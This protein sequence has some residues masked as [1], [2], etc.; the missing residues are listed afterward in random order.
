MRIQ[1]EQLTL[2]Q[3]PCGFERG[4]EFDLNLRNRFQLKISK[5][6]LTQISCSDLIATIR[7]TVRVYR[8]VPIEVCKLK[9]WPQHIAIG[10]L[11]E[12]PRY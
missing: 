7:S 6:V 5:D 1:F 3:Q 4:V 9:Y 2:T 11:T 10:T 12:E 8:E